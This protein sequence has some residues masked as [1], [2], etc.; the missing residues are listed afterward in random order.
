MIDKSDILSIIDKTQAQISSTL[1]LYFKILSQKAFGEWQSNKS[2]TRALTRLTHYVTS[3]QNKKKFYDDEVQDMSLPDVTHTFSEG[4]KNAAVSVSDQGV[5]IKSSASWAKGDSK[6]MLEALHQCVTMELLPTMT[7]VYFFSKSLLMT[8]GG[9]FGKGEGRD[10]KGMK[11]CHELARKRD[12][13]VP[14]N[15]ISSKVF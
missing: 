6:I 4:L 8:T 13:R 12:V 14:S 10:F 15:I 3:F 7:Q 1:R 2:T 5:N 9:S 11:S